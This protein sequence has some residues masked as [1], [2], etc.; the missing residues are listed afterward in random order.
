MDMTHTQK[1][2]YISLQKRRQPNTP[3]H[4]AH[5]LPRLLIPGQKSPT[6]LKKRPIYRYKRDLDKIC[7]YTKHTCLL[8]LLI[9]RQKTFW[10]QGKRLSDSTAKEPHMYRVQGERA[11]HMCVSCVCAY[12]ICRA[13]LPYMWGFLA[14]YVGLFGAS[15]SRSANQYRAK[16]PYIYQYR[17]KEPYIYRFWFQGKRASRVSHAGQKSPTYVC[18]ISVSMLY[19]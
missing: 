19:I 17:A 18:I 15:D 6:F 2:T 3:V 13:L 14:L 16:E 8:H 7:I 4:K 12:D 1:E 5:M 10:L 9:P 11:P